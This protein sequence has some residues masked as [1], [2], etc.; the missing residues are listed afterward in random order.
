ME[1]KDAWKGREGTGIGRGVDC[2]GKLSSKGE[3]AWISG[4]EGSVEWKWRNGDGERCGG[5][6]VIKW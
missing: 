4:E 3:R 2:A 1:K 6:I 5:K